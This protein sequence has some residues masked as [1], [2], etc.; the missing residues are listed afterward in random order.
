VTFVSMPSV[1]AGTL[2]IATP[3]NDIG[4]TSECSAM[5]VTVVT[6]LSSTRSTSTTRR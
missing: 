4:K 3:T 5:I 2:V 1:A 6:T